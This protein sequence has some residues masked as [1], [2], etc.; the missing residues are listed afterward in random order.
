MANIIK[1]IVTVTKI[2]FFLTEDDE[3]SGL[4]YIN[5]EQ[6]YISS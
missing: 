4:R 6:L 1:L 2:I 3:Y 5:R